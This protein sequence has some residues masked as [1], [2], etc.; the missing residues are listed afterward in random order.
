[1]LLSC[2]IQKLNNYHRT[3]APTVTNNLHYYGSIS[4][5]NPDSD[6]NSE[7]AGLITS[8]G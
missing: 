6:S 5:L 2:E 1:M 8:Q 4:D 3:F 7:D